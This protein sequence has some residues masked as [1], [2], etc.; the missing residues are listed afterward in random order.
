MILV[1]P[2][3]FQNTHGD[4]ATRGGRRTR[5]LVATVVNLR[6]AQRGADAFYSGPIAEAM[7]NAVQSKN[8]TMTLEDLNRFTD[9][10]LE[11][12]S[13]YVP[14]IFKILMAILPLEGAVVLVIS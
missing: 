10:S 5:D 11:K 14:R 4:T 12:K 2:E 7:I 3:N 6:V 8:G 9:C 13:L 1:C